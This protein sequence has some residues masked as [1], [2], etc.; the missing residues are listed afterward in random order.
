MSAQMPRIEEFSPILGQ[1]GSTVSQNAPVIT[2]DLLGAAMLAANSLGN[3]QIVSRENICSSWLRQGD[4]GFVFGERGVGK[5]WFGLDLARGIAE[6]R[7]I[8]P[9]DVPK[10]RKVLYVDGE[11]PIDEV[12]QRDASLRQGDGDLHFLNHEWLFEKTGVVLNLCDRSTQS[13]LTTCCRTNNIEVLVLDN[14]SCLFSGMEENKADA[15]ELVLPWLLQFRREKITVIMFHHANRGGQQ[16]R[17]TSR[18]EDA[19]FWVIRLDAVS[20]HN[21]E[22]EGARFVSRFT[23]A[24]Q[25]KR[26]EIEPLEWAYIPDGERTL[27]TFRLV[28]TIDVF[29]QCVRDGLTSCT[30]IAEEMGMTRGAISKL[31]TRGKNEGW[32]EHDGRSYRLV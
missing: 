4:L 11:M 14:L 25:G 9:W 24:R 8:G 31:A 29:R 23:K 16:M 30:D 3:I 28:K 21:R 7:K 13:A 2:A 5:T 6:G 12:R 32:L 19:A 26:S 1:A 27:T 15:W 18:R 17:G 10:S 20:E 22:G